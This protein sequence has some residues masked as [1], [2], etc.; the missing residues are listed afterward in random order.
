MLVFKTKIG[1]MLKEEVLH[2]AK[3]TKEERI[4]RQA[5]NSFERYNPG[6]D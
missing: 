6:V 3:G 4:R 1:I 5:H 2:V